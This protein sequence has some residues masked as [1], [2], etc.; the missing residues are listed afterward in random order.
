MIFN[1][2]LCGIAWITIVIIHALYK[3]NDETVKSEMVKNGNNLFS[4]SFSYLVCYEIIHF[5]NIYWIKIVICVLMY[6]F[7]ILPLLSAFLL[8]I[9][10]VVPIHQKATGLLNTV[11]PMIV[12]TNC[13]IAFIL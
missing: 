1:C 6:L 2:F 4:T 11:I 8:L 9:S 5:V 12:T 13:L 7:G 3:G 10:R